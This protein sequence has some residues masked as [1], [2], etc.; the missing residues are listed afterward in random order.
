[1]SI[2]RINVSPFR[3]CFAISHTSSFISEKNGLGFGAYSIYTYAAY[4][5]SPLA[6]H[7]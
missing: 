5:F 7:R 3:K 4:V 2:L 6:L 1:M